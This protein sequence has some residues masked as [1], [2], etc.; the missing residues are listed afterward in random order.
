MNGAPEARRKPGAQ[1]RCRGKLRDKPIQGRKEIPEDRRGPKTD[2]VGKAG[3][4]GEE[5]VRPKHAAFIGMAVCGG[6]ETAGTK[7]DFPRRAD[8]Y[9]ATQGQRKTAVK[10][11]RDA[12]QHVAVARVETKARNM[13]TSILRENKA[14]EGHCGRLPHQ[15]TPIQ[16]RGAR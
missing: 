16:R 14:E 2:L 10:N 12:L 15:G 7:L 4:E 11:P 1:P 13:A 6:Y 8:G 5:K 9:P 3:R